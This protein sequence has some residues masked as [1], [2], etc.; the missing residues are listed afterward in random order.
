MLLVRNCLAAWPVG[1]ALHF[2]HSWGHCSG[3]ATPRPP[4][5]PCRLG[6]APT[7]PEPRRECAAWL[8]ADWLYVFGGMG[9]SL[10]SVRPEVRARHE[11]NAASFPTM[12]RFHLAQC[13][14]A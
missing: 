12:W 2:V 5:A 11:L 7:A 1:A 3:H 13:R 8:H 6:R 9:N 4:A 10:E 14:Q